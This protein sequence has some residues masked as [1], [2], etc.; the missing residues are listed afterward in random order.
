[1]KTITQIQTEISGLRFGFWDEKA[2]EFIP[3]K[4]GNASSHKTAAQHLGCSKEMI[5]ALDILVDSLRDTLTQDLSDIWKRLD[6][7]DK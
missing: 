3:L 1:M 6:D 4:S 2:E 7:I 5:E